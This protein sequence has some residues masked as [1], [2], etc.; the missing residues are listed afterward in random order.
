VKSISQYVSSS[1]EKISSLDDY[2]NEKLK[3]GKRSYN[4]H[5]KTKEELQE[6]LK[7]LMEERGNDGDFNDIDTSQIT[8][9]SVLFKGMEKF[10]G[11]IS[12]WNVSNV[13]DMES[14]FRYCKSFNQDISKLD[15]SKVEYNNDVFEDCPIKEKYKPKLK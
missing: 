2:I 15:V 12:E 13:T 3:I 6:L 11:D 7:Q 14:M 4:Y 1:N 5:P 8:D 10:N 9:M